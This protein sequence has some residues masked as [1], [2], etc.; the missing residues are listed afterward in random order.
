MAIALKRRYVTSRDYR[1][2]YSEA[3]LLA[4]KIT[5]FQETLLPSHKQEARSHDFSS[6]GK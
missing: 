1:T 3:E 2:I 5:R 4:K 6:A